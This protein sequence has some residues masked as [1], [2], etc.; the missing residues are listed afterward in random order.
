MVNLDKNNN[1]IKLSKEQ[2]A[3]IKLLRDFH[4]E[5][6]INPSTRALINYAKSKNPSLN[7]DSLMFAKLFPKGIQQ[8]CSLANLPQSPRCL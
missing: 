8:A 7:L 4:N 5:F 2:L 6:S 3:V 1:K